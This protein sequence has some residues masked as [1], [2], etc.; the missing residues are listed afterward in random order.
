MPSL[1][2]H[3]TIPR[4]SSTKAWPN[5]LQRA[6]SCMDPSLPHAGWPVTSTTIHLIGDN[7]GVLR[8]SMHEPA[9]AVSP[10]VLPFSHHST[11]AAGGSPAHAPVHGDSS[12]A[13]R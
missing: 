8:G 1:R 12:P 4:A 5:L 13:P 3:N 10:L 9:A 2:G 7:V 6:R 11:R